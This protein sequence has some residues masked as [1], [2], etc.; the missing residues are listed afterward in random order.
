MIIKII[1]NNGDDNDEIN[2]DYHDGND[3][4]NYNRFYGDEYDLEYDGDDV[5]NKKNKK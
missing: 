2:N 3:D 1:V 4:D 5:R